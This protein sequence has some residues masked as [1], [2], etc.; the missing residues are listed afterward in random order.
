MTLQFTSAQIFDYLFLRQLDIS[1][2]KEE[3]GMYSNPNKTLDTLVQSL[4]ELESL[5]ISGTNL[6]GTGIAETEFV[7]DSSNCPQSDIPG[8]KSRVKRPLKFLGL[9]QTA[10]D[11]CLRH[12]IPAIKVSI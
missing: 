3:N 6:A 12:H 4:P 2:S 8:L 7:T 1:Q 9:Y 5:D 10:N 11:A